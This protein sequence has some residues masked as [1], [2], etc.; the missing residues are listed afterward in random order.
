MDIKTAYQILGLQEGATIED[1][2]KRFLIL[3]KKQQTLNY[4]KKDENTIEQINSDQTNEAYTVL[5]AY[6]LNEMN[7]KIE[8]S[9]KKSFKSNFQHYFY[10]YK[11]PAL[12]LFIVIIL[13]ISLIN[14]VVD[15][16]S[17]Q[18]ELAD[19]TP[20]ALN[21]TLFGEYINEDL[22]PF[23]NNL[24]AMF[25]EWNRIKVDLLYSP[26]E[27][28]SQQ[29]LG[30]AVKSQTILTE[31]SP[32]VLIVDA[33]QF[34]ILVSNGSFLSLDDISSEALKVAGKDRLLYDQT[35]DDNTEHLYGIN[36]TDSTIFQGAAISGSEKIAVIV[37][38]T[39]RF[40][41]ALEFVT[42][43]SKSID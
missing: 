23:Q 17:K 5:R 26:R 13:V 20:I 32:D 36:I 18:A 2:E 3:I 15:S 22:S 24:T 25:A 19:Q 42:K 8:V 43:T 11:Y 30:A 1:V 6:L 35:E 9:W 21:V 39:D 40:E 10:Y 37:K 41:R 4:L 38:G 16:K 27:T 28:N 33:H 29:D 31:S 7:D 34:D 12:G 14:S